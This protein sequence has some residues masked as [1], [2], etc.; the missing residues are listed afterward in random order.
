MIETT[1]EP[2]M[3]VMLTAMRNWQN[4]L[5]DSVALEQYLSQ[6]H[7]FTYTV[8]DKS[9]FLHAYPG[10]LNGIMVFFVMPAIY[11]VPMA[12]TAKIMLNTQTCPLISEYGSGSEIDPTIAKLR[13]SAWEEHYQTWIPQQVN[14]VDGMFQAFVIPSKQ[15]NADTYTVYMALAINDAVNPNPFYRADLILTN[16]LNVTY[17]DTVR[18]VPPFKPYKLQEFNMLNRL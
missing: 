8:V 4:I 6:G 10:I 3:E 1:V 2:T 18:P 13:I 16:S 15:L 12:S 7:Y 14:T 11:D 5:K 9:E 17:Y